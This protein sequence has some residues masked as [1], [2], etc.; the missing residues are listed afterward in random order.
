MQNIPKMSTLSNLKIRSP[1][2][3]QSKAKKWFETFPVQLS[4]NLGDLP[5][6]A[7]FTKLKYTDCLKI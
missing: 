2:D 5:Y 4:D 1:F 7:D 6:F 3:Q